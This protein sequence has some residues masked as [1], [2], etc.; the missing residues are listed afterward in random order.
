MFLSNNNKKAQP[1]RV[2]LTWQSSYE[3]MPPCR[4]FL[5]THHFNRL[6]SEFNTGKELASDNI[7]G[8][9]LSVGASGSAARKNIDLLIKQVISTY[10]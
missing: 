5:N 1:N 2:E 8:S 3:Y 9:R 6:K 10:I 7:I 4:G